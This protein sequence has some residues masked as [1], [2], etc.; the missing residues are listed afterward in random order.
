MRSA[1]A[2]AFAL[3]FGFALGSAGTFGFT[4]GST[5]T[6]GFGVALSG[7]SA[8]VSIGRMIVS[9]TRGFATG[10]SGRSGV[11]DLSRRL[12][13]VAAREEESSGAE[14]GESGRDVLE[15]HGDR[16]MHATSHGVHSEGFYAGSTRTRTW[17][18]IA[19]Q[20]TGMVSP[21]AKA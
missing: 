9:T 20:P 12:L 7:I 17:S 13:F 14:D 10:S 11:G 3:S 1:S 18:R 19:M 5:G 2:G 21:G 15:I 6:L 16:I 8:A 4:F